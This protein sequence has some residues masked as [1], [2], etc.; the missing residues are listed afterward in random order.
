ML[1]LTT[2]QSAI[3]VLAFG[4]LLAPVA[5]PAADLAQHAKSLEVAPEDA[6]FYAA[7]LKN[8]EQFDAVAKSNA[9]KQF[10]RIPVVSMGWIQ[11]QSQWKFPTDPTVEKFKNWF[12]SAQGQDVYGL[13]LDA[14]SDEVFIYGDASVTA[15]TKTLLEMNSESTRAQFDALRESGDPEALDE[16]EAVQQRMLKLLKEHKDELRVPNLVMGFVIDDRDRAVRVLDLANTKLRELI[17]SEDDIPAWVGEQL[18]R[19]QVDDRELLVLT[20]TGDQLPWGVIEE[21]MADQPELFDVVKELVEDKQMVVALAVVDNFLLLSVSESLEYLE[22]FGE[23]DLLSERDEF[24]RL[25]QHAGENIISL[26]YASEEFMRAAGSQQRSMGDMAAMAKGFLSLAELSEEQVEAIEGDIDEL[27]EATL[28]YLPTPGA[29]AAVSFTTDRGYE[30][31]T[32]NWGEMPPQMDASQKLTLIDH[33]GEDSLGWYVARGKQS[34]D[35]YDKMVDWIKRIYGHVDQIAEDKMAGE[36]DYE[37]YKAIRDQVLPLLADLDQAN[38]EYLIPGFKDGQSAIVLDASVSDTSWCEFMNASDSPLP[39][40]SIV[41]VSGVSD[42]E[43]VKKGT[44]VYWDVA[45]RAIDKAHEAEPDEIPAF[46]LPEPEVVESGSA[47]TIYQYELP[48]AWGANDRVKPNAGLSDSVLVMSM[49]PELTEKLLAGSRP[50]VD[51]PAAEFDRPLLAAGHF[52]FAKFI[53]TLRPWADYGIQLAMEQQSGEGND[54]SMMVGMAK[55]QVEMLLEVLQAF[56]SYT[57]VTYKDDD[58]WVKHGEM[59]I[60]DLD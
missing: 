38:R 13:A 18:T 20:L 52:E 8:R 44:A 12:D 28:D 25:E 15:L 42:A 58:V 27:I 59:R 3:A 29:V 5:A 55:P 2:R 7:S 39:M 48:A 60:K 36:E 10:M 37:E 4:L 21:K 43:A 22:D 17:E 53:E 41:L 9:W 14:V 24:D 11:V 56:D 35:T 6:A 31:Y 50:T 16:N 49:F 51:G 54:I 1:S 34:V 33:V 45:Q 19:E 23:G 40:P 26:G 32:Y 57:G 30:S 47:G 46:T